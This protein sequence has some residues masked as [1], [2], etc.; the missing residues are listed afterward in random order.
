MKLP[1]SVMHFRMVKKLIANSSYTLL[2][3]KSPLVIHKQAFFL[4]SIELSEEQFSQF[5][6]RIIGTHKGLTHK[7]SVDVF[8]LHS[9]NIVTI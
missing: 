4:C 8:L 1:P 6:A 7:K 2:Q 9:S 3:E 5:L